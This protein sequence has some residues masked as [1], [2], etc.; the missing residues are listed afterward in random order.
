MNLFIEIENGQP[1]NHPAFKENLIQSFNTVPE[2]WEP[3]VRSPRPVKPVYQM[4]DTEAPAYK[5]IDG[6]WTDAWELRNMTDAE[7]TALQQEEKDRWATLPDRDN[8]ADWIFDE[9]QCCFVAPVDCPQDGKEYLWQGTTSSWVEVPQYPDDGKTY[10][11]SFAT[12]AWV[13]VTK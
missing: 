9:A 1:K 2:T 3:F 10:K 11:L 6:V 7:K 5:K 8:F 12:A 4:F 13:L